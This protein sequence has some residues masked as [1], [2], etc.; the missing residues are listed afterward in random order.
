MRRWLNVG[1]SLALGSVLTTACATAMTSA[2]P[3]ADLPRHSSVIADTKLAA[4]Y[5]QR[6][7]ASS[8]LVPKN[9]WSWATYVQGIQALYRVS[10]DAK[11]LSDNLAWGQAN[12]WSLTNRETDPDSVKAAQ[13]YYDLNQL[14]PAASLTATN[15]KMASD[16]TRL[17]ITEYDWADALFMGLPNWTRAAA[18]TGNAAYL[19]KMDAL[20][21]WTRDKGGTSKRCA[22]KPAPV[23][24]L[25][26]PAEGLWYRDC[27]FV[28][29]KDAH[30]RKVFW[31]RGNGWVIAAMAQVLATLPKGSPH[32]A[33]YLAMFKTMSSSLIRLQGSDG[34]WRTS[35]EDPSL[36]PT[37][38]TS[39]TALITY[40]LAYGI[41]A[42]ILDAPTYLPAVAKAWNG[43]TT[44]SLQPSGFVTD[45]QAVGYAPGPS[46]TAKSPA[47]VNTDEP[48]YCAGAF[49]L[50]G[51]AVAALTSSPS[52]GKAVTST[53]Q[54]VGHEASRVN[55][56]NVT[57][58]WSAKGFPKSVTI[59][60]G[61]DYRLSNS[62][63]VPY[64]D[65]AYRYRI[66]TSTDRIHWTRVVDR[67]TNTAGGTHVDDF[68]QG[69][70]NARYVRLTVTG[71]SGV[72]TA[73]ASIQEFAVYDRFDPRVDLARGHITT[74]S[75]AIAG[76]PFSAATDGSSATW[77]AT[78]AAPTTARPQYLTV[79]LG[80]IVPI[81]TVRLF[82]RGSAGPE[83]VT[84]SVSSVSGSAYRTV[85][86]AVLGSTEGP[87]AVMFP[88]TNAR[89]VRVTATSSHASNSMAVEQF[90][91]FRADG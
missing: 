15:A 62:M 40:A 91:V 84:V 9:G 75:S 45:C 46:Y 65:R 11:Y 24:A 28:G 56:G 89:W 66:D 64:A 67:S 16:L 26:D 74:G 35:L 72:N 31:S 60:L 76:H 3:M 61:N 52:T 20:F 22:A 8:T 4:D 44:I 68:V 14:N 59:D 37:P 30:G 43:L 47:H 1:V 10:G 80:G 34:M 5:Y 50:A 71:I 48:P 12:S 90:E 21:A 58:H 87:G 13:T 57:T 42:G 6:T 54:Q 29:V 55:D 88:P 70:V 82:S 2:V 69:T 73:W 85:A 7:F 23:Q 36:Y 32:A 18:R 51:S 77:W 33:K 25:Y 86:S 63:V 17:P 81:D 41:Q 53:G 79:N 49:L 38:E 78:S 39:G 19:N 27:T 83:R